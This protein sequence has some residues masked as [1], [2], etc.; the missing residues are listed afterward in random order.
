[1]TAYAEEAEVG[2]GYAE[3]EVAAEYVQGDADTDA[4]PASKLKSYVFMIH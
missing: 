2:A 4:D 3:T 1:M